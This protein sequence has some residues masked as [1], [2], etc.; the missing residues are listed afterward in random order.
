MGI[1]GRG[2]DLDLNYGSTEVSSGM[3]ELGGFL[4]F[5]LTFLICKDEFDTFFFFRIAVRIKKILSIK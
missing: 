1:V 3:C 4:I 5:L 2:W